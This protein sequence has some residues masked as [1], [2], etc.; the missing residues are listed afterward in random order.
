MTQFDNR[1]KAAEAHFALDQEMQFRVEARTAKLAAQWLANKI[2]LTGDAAS[3]YVASVI[4]ANLAESGLD[5]LHAKLLADAAAHA[6]SLD[7]TTIATEVER[8]LHQATQE[9]QAKD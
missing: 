7:A 1:E 8:C 2:G 3:T 4:S 6:L 9:L 5:D